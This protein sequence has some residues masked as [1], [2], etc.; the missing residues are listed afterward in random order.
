MIVDDS[1]NSHFPTLP[2][3]PLPLLIYKSFVSIF[4]LFSSFFSFTLL[5]PRSWFCV[6]P[7]YLI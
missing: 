1:F 7:F 3:D 4:F 2:A 5:S 6:T